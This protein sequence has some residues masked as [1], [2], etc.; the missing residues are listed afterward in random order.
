[1]CILL[2]IVSKL[3][4]NNNE[5][6]LILHQTTCL[7]VRTSDLFVDCFTELPVYQ[8]AHFNLFGWIRVVNL[9][10]G[11]LCTRCCECMYPLWTNISRTPQFGFKYSKAKSIGTVFKYRAK[12]CIWQRINCGKS[13]K[14]I[15]MLLLYRLINPSQFRYCFFFI[16][17]GRH[18][19][20]VYSTAVLSISISIENYCTQNKVNRF[21]K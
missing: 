12:S 10:F 20:M 15:V 17:N 13:E 9:C 19:K 4:N 1:M 6:M 2:V 16:L 18:R 3:P 7:F 14:T 5:F 8:I 21:T 11:V